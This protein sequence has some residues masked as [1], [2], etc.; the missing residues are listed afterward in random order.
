M[1]AAR[2]DSGTRRYALCPC[3]PLPEKG[4]WDT[5]NAANKPRAVRLRLSI[6]AASY[7]RL[8]SRWPAP[9]PAE[10]PERMVRR[11]AE[12]VRDILASVQISC[13]ASGGIQNYDA[14][15]E[16]VTVLVRR[17]NGDRAIGIYRGIHQRRRLASREAH[18]CVECEAAIRFVNPESRC[19]E[20]RELDQ[21][22]FIQARQAV[23]ANNDVLE[24]V[25]RTGR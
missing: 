9:L 22:A 3:F 21:I 11:P 23:A 14:L 17:G 1:P 19:K 12:V 6:F 2:R 4:L 5:M 20:R 16:G 25:S 7:M 10:T 8:G 18:G 13:L 24:K 15:V